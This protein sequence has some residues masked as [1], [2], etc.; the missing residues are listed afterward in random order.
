MQ[1]S[2]IIP[3][4]HNNGTI[5]ETVRSADAQTFRDFEILLIDNGRTLSDA[6]RWD[7]SDISGLRIL[8]TET[9]LGA[10]GARNY[11]V[12]EAKGKYVA[13]LDADDRWTPDKLESE[14]ALMNQRLYQDETPA[15]VCAGRRVI[16]SNGNERGYIGCEPV[17]TYR[18]ILHSNQINC[19]SVLVPRSTMLKYPFPDGNLHEDYYVWLEILR[20]G[21]YAAGI[22]RP[23]MDYR[24]REGSRSGNKFRSARMNLNVYRKLGIPAPKRFL[25]MCSYML[26][27]I[28]KYRGIR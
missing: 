20:E 24:V 18:K 25:Y 27:G 26:A 6:V 28:R 5:T 15:L 10:A 8:E 12:R 7:L 23:L 2:V 16:D 22:N 21:G 13:F 19:S 17:I 9:A 3:F 14:L 4:Y 1:V 11:G